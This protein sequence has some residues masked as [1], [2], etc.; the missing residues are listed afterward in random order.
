AAP[1]P[2]AA[3][4]PLCTVS[5]RRMRELSGLVTVD[6]GYVAI[7]DSN[8]DRSAIRVFFLDDR[9]RLTKSV[10]YPTAA[11]DPED[12]ATAPDGGL[13]VADIGDNFNAKTH[14]TTVAVWRLSPGGSTPVIHRLVYPDG[15][16]DAEALLID[17]DG[18]PLLITKEILGS[19]RIYKP[20]RALAAGTA[21]GV[22][23]VLVGRFTPQR[24]GTP[25]PFGA[26]GRLAVTGAATAPDRRRVLLRTYADAYEFDVPDGDVV[27]ALTGGTP[28]VTPLPDEPQGEAITYTH[29]ATGFVTVS[30]AEGPAPLL[31]YA[32]TAAGEE[33]SDDAADAAATAGADP[34]PAS[35]GPAERARLSL[36]S[37]RTVTTLVGAFGVALVLGLML[38]RGRAGRQPGPRR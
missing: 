19:A 8:G 1:A 18:L 22:P 2:A 21:A 23:L 3:G 9:C 34:A 35:S 20:S 12:L 25:N 32:P 7:N 5:D 10:G 38:A 11:R 14:R 15:H 24:T 29:D 30:D 26:T 6:S 36:A 27:A 4:T 37:G 17:G 13:W 33:P 16:H 28:R 31:R